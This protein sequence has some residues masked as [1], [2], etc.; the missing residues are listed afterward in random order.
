MCICYIYIKLQ[1]IRLLNIKLKNRL[2]LKAI[3]CYSL[4]NLSSLNER[5][6]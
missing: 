5:L 1:N 6:M 4:Q 3:F 2:S